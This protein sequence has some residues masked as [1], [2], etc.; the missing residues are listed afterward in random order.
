MSEAGVLANIVSIGQPVI[1]AAA[2]AAS[3]DVTRRDYD[4]LDA[5]DRRLRTS[6]QQGTTKLRRLSKSPLP[7]SFSEG[8][9]LCD[10]GCVDGSWW[11]LGFDAKQHVL[12][13]EAFH[14]MD[15][16]SG[17]MVVLEAF[18]LLA[19]LSGT[20][21]SLSPFHLLLENAQA[22]SV[23]ISPFE[24][25]E[26]RDDVVELE[27]FS[28][29]WQ[30]TD[31]RFIACASPE[32]TESFGAKKTAG[33]DVTAV[34]IMGGAAPEWV[35]TVE[36]EIVRDQSAMESIGWVAW[37]A[38]IPT[39]G[40]ASFRPILSDGAVA[41]GDDVIA[42]THAGSGGWAWFEAVSVPVAQAGI[43]VSGRSSSA[44]G[45]VPTEGSIRNVCD[46]GL[47]VSFVGQGA[48]V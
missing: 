29:L 43:P 46:E 33:R 9:L 3:G 35:E 40:S 38:A 5:P 11:G 1:R 34:G 21:M 42:E 6:F 31:S 4:P 24:I 14:L 48:W 23:T 2:G 27:V 47:E 22:E 41:W 36:A 39:D 28:V 8:G 10:G 17:E 13:I 19:S 37:W 32:W 25:L 12:Q 15:G 18:H 20:M 44:C 26:F 45:T 30:D 7:P 16:G